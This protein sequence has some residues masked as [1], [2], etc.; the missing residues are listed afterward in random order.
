MSNIHT[1]LDYYERIFRRRSK[2]GFRRDLLPDP[3]EF[4]Q[5]EIESLRVRAGEWA[6]GRCPFHDDRTPSLSVNFVSGAYRCF[7]CGARG[8]DV[9]DFYRQ[10]HG[11]GFIEAAKA[12]G[13]WT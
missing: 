3:R 5:R 8:G 9:L 11:L 13:A 6:Q 12:L 7:G 1:G 2:H 4:Y 10:L